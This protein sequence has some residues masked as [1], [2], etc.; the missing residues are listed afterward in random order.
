MQITKAEAAKEI[1][2]AAKAAGLTFKQQNAR[3]GGSQAYKFTDRTTGE[4]VMSNCT[5]GT[6]YDNVCSGFISKYN[7]ETRSFD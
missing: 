7:K 5:I 2:A 3:I 6:A 4:T 1:R